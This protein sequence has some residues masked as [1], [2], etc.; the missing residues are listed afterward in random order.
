MQQYNVPL[1]SLPGFN[2][3]VDLATKFGGKLDTS[4]GSFRKIPEG[5]PF[6]E[7]AKDMFSILIPDDAVVSFDN[8]LTLFGFADQVEKVDSIKKAA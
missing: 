1:A 6:L 4:E 5:H 8:I 3:A 2:A 7:H